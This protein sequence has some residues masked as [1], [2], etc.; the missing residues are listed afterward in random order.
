MWNRRRSLYNHD[1][2]TE[3]KIHTDGIVPRVAHT[4]Y[5]F[6]FCIWYPSKRLKYSKRS[7]RSFSYFCKK[8]R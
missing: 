5:T 6:S 2:I 3:M 1:H 7:R 8:T 4:T